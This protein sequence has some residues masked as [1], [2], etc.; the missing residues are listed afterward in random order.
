MIVIICVLINVQVFSMETK[1]H[2]AMSF[3]AIVFF[4]VFFI[5]P[6]IFIVRLC[7]NFDKLHQKNWKIHYEE[8]YG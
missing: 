8:L 5:V 7:R 3:I 4:I 2:A 6:I 1:G